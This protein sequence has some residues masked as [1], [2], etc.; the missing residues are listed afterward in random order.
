MIGF[1]KKKI[2]KADLKG[3]EGLGFLSTDWDLVPQQRSQ[4]T[5]ESASHSTFGNF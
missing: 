3:R 2:F 1:I 5:E 4:M